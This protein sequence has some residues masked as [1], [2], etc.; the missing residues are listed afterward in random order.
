MRRHVLTVLIGACFLGSAA[1]PS[2]RHVAVGG[3]DGAGDGSP[4]APFASIGH[5][6][7]AALNGDTV[8]VG[9]GTYVENIDF[10]GRRVKVLSVEGADVTRI[11]PAVSGSP[12]VTFAANEDTTTVID[13]FTIA[14]ATGAPGILCSGASP[15]IQ[16]C[17]LQSCTHSGD[18]GGIACRGGSKAVIR[19]NTFWG[20]TAV[21][22]GG[23]Y[24]RQ[25]YPIITRNIFMH[26]RADFGAG[27]AVYDNGYP[28]VSYNLFAHNQAARGGGGIASIRQ[29]QQPLVIEYCT[30]FGN[31][32]NGS[33]GGVY[34]EMSYLIINTSILWQDAAAAA[35]AE[36][37]GIGGIVII[38]NNS[39][40]DGGWTGS[41]SGN[42]DVDPL[43]CDPSG[44]DFHLLESSPVAEYP[45][46]NGNP[47]GAYGAG[48]IEYSCDDADGDGVCDEDDNCVLTANAD[49][50]DADTDGLGDACDNCPDYANVDQ[51]DTDGDAVGDACDNCP[52]IANA[53]QFDFDGD[54]IGNACDN[55]PDVANIDQIDV[56]G[57]GKGAA[58]DNCPDMAN[59]DQA[60][61]DGDGIGDVCDNCP[62][63]SN[64]DQS[65]IDGDGAGDLC[66]NC[67]EVVNADQADGDGDGVGDVCDNCPDMA[68]FD[69]A[70][71]DRD[72]IGDVCDNCP[73]IA[74]ADQVDGDGD[75]IGDGCDNCPDT[76]NTEQT[77]VDE[78]GIGDLCDNCP[79]IANADQAD[80]DGDGVGDVCDN[81]PE[82]AN[83][84]QVDSDGDGV[85]NGCDNC[86][87]M[88][89]TNQVDADGDGVGNGCDNCP[90]MANTNQVDADGDG[91]GN[92]CDNCPEVANSGQTDSDGDGIGDACAGAEADYSIAGN[93]YGDSMGLAGVVLDLLDDQ[94]RT[95]TS[96]V[97]GD[98][99][100]YQ[101]AELSND[102]YLVRV[103]P[104]FGYSIAEDAQEIAVTG[105]IEGVDFYLVKETATG[106]W[107]GPG[108]WKHQL[109]ALLHGQ[110]HAHETYE[111]MCD[112][113]ERIRLYFNENPQY[114]IR[115]FTVDVAVDC[116]QRLFD[117]E[118]ILSPKPRP[119]DFLQAQGQ[120]AVLLLNLVSGRIP[121]WA[122]VGEGTVSGAPGVSLS[123][124][125]GVTVS[126]GVT[127]CDELLIDG[128]AGNDRTVYDIAHLINV[129]E[130]VPDGWIDPSTPNV[131]YMGTLDADDDATLPGQYALDQNYPNP[132]NPTTSIS[133]TMAKEASVR[134]VVYNLLGQ[135]VRALV[136]E[137]K[138]A[139]QHTVVWDGADG[140]GRTVA[141]GVYHYR[142]IA[143]DYMKSRKMLLLK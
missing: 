131:D 16:N 55:C 42:A 61:G 29:N 23:V 109:K 43:F 63:F 87:D 35:G 54:G 125:I 95:I 12:I 56:D 130:P 10:S 37:Y 58:C 102:T 13:G 107:R 86:P 21:S 53:D 60:D 47:I 22:G 140:S 72:G 41:G 124:A 15:T 33:G 136:D 74:N 104:P 139:G 106:K 39:D 9:A 133:Y 40:V 67:P 93:V 76:A 4:S 51:I 24:C 137:V 116:E 123:P 89:N 108:Y 84:D 6:I 65:D 112:Y 101:F 48:C 98:E 127:F 59:F 121:P 119:T 19:Y 28:T 46:N 2:T 70:D 68:N 5:A 141:S 73:E 128:D 34:S 62:E 26:N 64:A 120:F 78:D 71:G 20:N 38:V 96:A 138:Q 36:I 18:G 115:G 88:A 92:A 113:L 14:D 27:I 45:F 52:E 129:G 82:V 25:S 7:G 57:D 122:D 1:F 110:G 117:L 100:V 81:C 85:G 105:Q 111:D 50:A 91:V 8:L 135:P 132:F 69:Q 66:D 11:E 44:G 79:E 103:W 126:Q 80:G 75:G 99:G 17:V 114:P 90:D 83:S 77:D 49:Q 30:L 3:D 143:G 31:S 118:A 94:G 32:S 134:L 142:L 97:T